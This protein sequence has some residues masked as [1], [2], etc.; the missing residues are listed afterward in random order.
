MKQRL[1]TAILSALVLTAGFNAVADDPYPSKPIMTIVAF[2]AG[3]GTDMVARAIVRT[4]EKYTGKGFVVDN[5]PG[6]GGAIGFTALAGAP[7]DGYTIGFINAPTIVLNPIQLAD[8]V[9]YKL[10]DFIPIANFVNDPGVFAVNVE[11][12]F[13]TLKDFIDYAKANPNKARMAYGGPGTNEALTLRNMEQKLGITFR[14]VPFEGTGPQL[15]ALMGGHID[16]MISSAGDIYPQAEAKT[17]RVI[18]IGAQKQIDLY[19]GVPTFK[20]AGFDYIHDSFRGMAVPKGMDPKQIS[21]LAEAMKKAYDDPE[22]KKTAK[23]LHLPLQFLGPEDFA[24]ELKRMDT[25]Y[26]AEFAKNP[27]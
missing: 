2:P 16:I 25:F 26:R 10:D 7:K 19:P 4:A 18:A 24:K 20:E 5:K 1:M 15:T 11:S 9:K 21:I 17:I 6:A 23:E 22:F 3:G 27:W 12:P 13:K 8:K 14:K